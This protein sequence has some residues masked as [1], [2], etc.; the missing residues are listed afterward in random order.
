M[1]SVVV[2]T[3]LENLSLE[4]VMAGNGVAGENQKA[5]SCLQSNAFKAQDGK[6]EELYDNWA[7][8]YED[9][10][11]NTLGFASPGMC[12]EETAKILAHRGATVLDVGCGTGLLADLLIQKGFEC[13]FIGTDLSS[14]MLSLAARKNNYQQLIQQNCGEL[15]WPVDSASV[16]ACMCN[17]VLIYVDNADCLDEFVRV[18]KVGGYCVLMFRHD[19]YPKYAAKDMELRKSGKW[20]LVS[21]SEDCKNF[22][23]TTDDDPS[24]KVVFNIWTYKVIAH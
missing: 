19:G 10:S 3:P 21:K 11:L 5:R 13:T 2:A 4:Q 16:D 6:V 8:T 14:Q 18:T 7:A 20:Q 23:C 1:D 15:P 17:G 22:Q 24:S 12:A 9:D